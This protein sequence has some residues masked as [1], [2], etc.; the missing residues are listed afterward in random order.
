MSYALSNPLFEPSED[1]DDGLL[2]A[3]LWVNIAFVLFTIV[4]DPQTKWVLPEL[5]LH[6]QGRAS[7]PMQVV[8]LF[9]DYSPQQDVMLRLDAPD[10]SILSKD[11]DV[12][13]VVSAAKN[14]DANAAFRIVVSGQEPSGILLDAVAKLERAGAADVTLQQLERKE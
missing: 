1:D 11:K 12:E 14:D 7:E 2:W 8:T 5:K 13:A 6:T 9:V 4:V 3:D 10:G